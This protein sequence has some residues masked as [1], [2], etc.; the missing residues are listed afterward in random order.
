[1]YDRTALHVAANAAG[2][3]NSNQLSIAAGVS[4]STAWRMWEG[5]NTPRYDVAAKIARTVGLPVDTLYRTA[6]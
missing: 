3:E 2:I 6:A 1:M 5:K 4:A